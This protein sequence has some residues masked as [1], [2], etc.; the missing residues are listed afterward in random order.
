MQIHSLFLGCPRIWLAFVRV[1]FLFVFFTEV[2]QWHCIHEDGM[3]CLLDFLVKNPKSTLFMYSCKVLQM[4]KFTPDYLM[5]KLLIPCYG[6]TETIPWNLK[7]YKQC[8]RALSLLYRLQVFSI[9]F[10]NRVCSQ[11]WLNFLGERKKKKV[12]KCNKVLR[13]QHEK[14]VSIFQ[15]I[16]NVKQ[17]KAEHL[18]TNIP[19]FQ[20][21]S[22]LYSTIMTS[23]T[24]FSTSLLPNPC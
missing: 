10:L 19:A 13:S 24:G 23:V 14:W 11:M 1:W 7:P 16:L 9:Q 12:L 8:N 22:R 17:F 21:L 3:Q 15:S 6:G 2:I 5:Q 4:K 20:N 18:H